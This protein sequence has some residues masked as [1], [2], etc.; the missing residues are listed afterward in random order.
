MLLYALPFQ[1]SFT[2][3]SSSLPLPLPN[4]NRLSKT[5]DP[6]S[7]HCLAW[8][9]SGP[10]STGGSEFNLEDELYREGGDGFDEFEFSGGAKKR[11][12]WSFD[13]GEDDDD[14]GFGDEEDGFWVFQVIRAFGWMVPAIAVSFLL[15]TG[16]SNAFV[17]ALAVPLGQTVVSLVVDKVWGSA[18]VGRK[19][20]RR[21]KTVK[22]PFA[23][24]SYRTKTS[25]RKE[26][27][28]RARG[29]RTSYQS[30]VAGSDGSRRNNGKGELRFGGWDELDSMSQEASRG[31]PIEKGYQRQEKEGKLS[32]RGRV[33]D[34]PLLIRLM[35]AMF[36][37]LGSWTKFLF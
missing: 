1:L 28:N 13:D 17:M 37:F 2:T 10:T 25:A 18:S 35:I 9:S 19:A 29:K 26:D 4:P 27:L 3:P 11:A 34:T 36:P 22:K 16:N 5:W 12:W 31:R 6:H 7:I 23:Q 20:R 32:R 15:G 8:K 30:W 24:A 14:W 21:T 33:R